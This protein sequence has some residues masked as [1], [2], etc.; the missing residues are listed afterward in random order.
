MKYRRFTIGPWEKLP[1]SVLFR[2][3]TFWIPK[4][5]PDFEDTFSEVE[6][7][8]LEI[9]DSGQVQRE[10]GFNKSGEPV[11][12]A[13]LGKNLGIFTD[14]ARAPKP[15]EALVSRDDFERYFARFAAITILKS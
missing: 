5:N 11:T 15:L 3:L 7:F 8:W 6:Y 14:E 2:V 9:D 13:P 1:K 4:A 12:A 10:I